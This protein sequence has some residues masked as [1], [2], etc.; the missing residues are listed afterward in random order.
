MPEIGGPPCHEHCQVLQESMT[1]SRLA[2]LE[3]MCEQ[4]RITISYWP[5]PKRLRAT[6][7]SILQ[8]CISQVDHFRNRMNRDLCVYKLGMTSHPPLRFQFYQEANYTC[9]TLLHV[10]E[11][12]GVAQMLEAALI[13]SNMSQQGCRNERFG[14]EGP[15]AVESEQFHFVY[16]VGARADCLKAIR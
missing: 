11:N 1:R 12:L 9:M 16:I 2:D 10:T 3:M 8:R 14:G 13:A 7:G 4:H 15:P 5:S 6:A